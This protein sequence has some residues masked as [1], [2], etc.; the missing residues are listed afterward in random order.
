MILTRKLRAKSAKFTPQNWIL[1]AL[2]AALAYLLNRFIYVVITL[3]SIPG[4]F[5][6]N[7]VFFS[8]LGIV[9]AVLGLGFIGLLPALFICLIAGITQMVI[10]G[11]SFLV[12]LSQW[13]FLLLLAEKFSKP[14]ERGKR[15]DLDSAVCAKFF[16]T[17]P[18]ID[19][20]PAFSAVA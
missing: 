11:Q 3:P 5:D 18:V 20:W 14:E 19:G 2:L 12:V 16:G 9:P 4:S 6:S 7:P 8:L 13:A 15:S 17:L 10:H 1:F